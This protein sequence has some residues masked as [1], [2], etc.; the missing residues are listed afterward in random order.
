MGNNKCEGGSQ[1][2]VERVVEGI[3]Y[4]TLNQWGKE[5]Q[6]VIYHEDT[7]DNPKIEISNFEEKL[8]IEAS[9]YPIPTETGNV[10]IRLDIIN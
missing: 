7:P 3:F 8:N 2:Y 9:L 4:Q 6:F 5:Y 10:I 1:A